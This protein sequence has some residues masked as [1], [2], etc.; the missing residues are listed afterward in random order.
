MY[1]QSYLLLFSK[2]EF[3]VIYHLVAIGVDLKIFLKRGKPRK[4]KFFA[5]GVQLPRISTSAIDVLRFDVVH[6]KM[7]EY[8]LLLWSQPLSI[9]NSIS[10]LMTNRL[11]LIQQTQNWLIT[12]TFKTGSSNACC[13]CSGDSVLIPTATIWKNSD[14]YT[15]DASNFLLKFNRYW[16]SIKGYVY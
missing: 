10:T 3:L 7:S 4:S 8:S 6:S 14:P 16:Y 12:E 11:W 15:Y 1:F 9:M 2:T 5:S 13:I